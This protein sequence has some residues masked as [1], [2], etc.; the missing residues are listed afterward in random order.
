MS[1]PSALRDA[2]RGHRVREAAPGQQA[3]S[4]PDAVPSPMQ[5]QRCSPACAL[6]GSR[7]R[8]PQSHSSAAVLSPRRHRGDDGK[9][10]RAADGLFRPSGHRMQEDCQP[11]GPSTC[12]APHAVL[13]AALGPLLLTLSIVGDSKGPS[14]P[15]LGRRRHLPA[16]SSLPRR[17]PALGLD[18]RQRPELTGRH[19]ASSPPTKAARVR[20]HLEVSLVTSWD[21]WALSEAKSARVTSVQPASAWVC[22]A[23]EEAGTRIRRHSS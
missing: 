16:G 1:L 19:Q 21:R 7:R 12:T 22:H 4:P 23:Q 17:P 3:S 2:P 14:G 15:G 10:L 6:T 8:D 13:T 9:R 20:G 5:D 11:H 18:G